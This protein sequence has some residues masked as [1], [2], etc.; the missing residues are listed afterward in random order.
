[1]T[2][3]STYLKKRRTALKF[4][5]R[6][7]KRKFGQSRFHELRVEIKKL[8]ATLNRLEFQLKDFDGERAYKPFRKLFAQAGKVREIQIQKSI[9]KSQDVQGQVPGYLKQL[10]QK[11]R[12]ER[13]RFFKIRTVKLN[14][15]IKKRLKELGRKNR[16]AENLETAPFLNSLIGEI[17]ELLLSGTLEQASAHLLRKKLKNL[18]YNLESLSQKKAAKMHPERNH[19][20]NLLGTWHDLTS[21]QDTLL[22][23]VSSTPLPEEEKTILSAINQKIKSESELIFAEINEKIPL[24]DDFILPPQLRP[25]EE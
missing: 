1:M 10:D 2:T 7:P 22:A 6:T 12:K 20:I 18:A 17:K 4:L 11:I 21:V 13:S 9:L 3:G 25:V 24:F 15:K 23:Q 19:L 8:R 5:T 14:S 16:E